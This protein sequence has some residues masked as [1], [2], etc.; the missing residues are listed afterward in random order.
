MDTTKILDDWR[1]VQ[2]DPHLQQGVCASV[3]LEAFVHIQHEV[4]VVHPLQLHQHPGFQSE[5]TAAGKC[6]MHCRF[7]ACAWGLR[8]CS[9]SQSYIVLH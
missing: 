6:A 8:G 4:V 3:A 9:A 7:E 5:G 1:Q 2:Q